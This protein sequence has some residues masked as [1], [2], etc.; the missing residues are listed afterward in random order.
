MSILLIADKDIQ[1]RRQVMDLFGETEY[2]IVAPD[3][4]DMVLGD[5]LKKEVR[6]ILL[7]SEF[8]DMPAGDLIPILKRCNR[9]LTIILISNEQSLPLLRKLRREGIF[10][11]ALRPVE[12]E[13]REEILQAVQCAFEN[14]SEDTLV[15][16]TDHE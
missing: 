11:H 5:V 15:V 2:Q 6:V 12:K 16:S 4:V 14:I 7:G 10:Y 1:A 13:D 8:D 3:S 9:N